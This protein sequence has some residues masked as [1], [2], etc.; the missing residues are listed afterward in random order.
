M[1]TTGQQ[2]KKEMSK[3]DITLEEYLENYDYTRDA[4]KKYVLEL[5]QKGVGGSFE[6][7]KLLSLVINWI[8]K[9]L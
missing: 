8:T 9:S 3:E 4:F 2:I 5:I 7:F 6:D 1:K